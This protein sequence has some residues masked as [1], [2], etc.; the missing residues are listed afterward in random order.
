MGGYHLAVVPI[1]TRTITHWTGWVEVIHG[2]HALVKVHDYVHGDNRE[3]KLDLSSLS[4]EDRE[5]ISVG[6]YFDY[7]VT[8]ENGQIKTCLSI[9]CRQWYPRI[10]KPT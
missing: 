2:D 1:L 3:A 9:D 5:K 7:L 6:I 8:E 4:P 10:I